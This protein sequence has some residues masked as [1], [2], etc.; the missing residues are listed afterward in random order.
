MT[1]PVRIPGL[2]DI[3]IEPP[4]VRS[5]EVEDLA[6]DVIASFDEFEPIATA[7]RECGLSIEYVFETRPFDPA[8]DEYHPHVVAKVTKSSP[9]WLSLTG[10]HLVIQFRRWFWERFDDSQRR[11]VLHH[12][13][14]HVEVDEPDGQGRIPV[15]LRKHDVEDFTQTMRR[16]GPVIPGR[17]A[18]IRAA[19]EW[20]REHPGALGDGDP[21]GERVVEAIA[22]GIDSVRRTPEEIAADVGR[23]PENEQRAVHAAVKGMRGLIDLAERTGTEVTVSA[24]GT[25]ATFGPKKAHSHSDDA[26]YA[27]VADG[28]SLAQAR[29]RIEVLPNSLDIFGTDSGQALLA[30]LA[31]GRGAHVP[32]PIGGAS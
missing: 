6:L 15:R 4:F 21:V 10:T 32:F 13:L 30:A 1:D 12:E 24:M 29:A 18:F 2:L 16:F 14:T 31:K 3:S 11:A 8:K 28:E 25:S 17:A 5:R 9:L 7:A 23:L 20:G 22:R 27:L 26:F 19:A